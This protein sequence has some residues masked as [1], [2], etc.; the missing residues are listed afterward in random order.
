M[1][2]IQ[3]RPHQERPPQNA[4]RPPERKYLSFSQF[5]GMNTRNARVGLD[6]TDLAW[7]EN[8]M[9]IGPN[10][11][12]G[13][14]GPG[15]AIAVVPGV[16]FTKIYDVFLRG[17]HYKICF[18]TNGAGYQIDDVTG[19]PVVFAPPGT[20]SLPDI[21]VYRAER[22]LIADPTAG[23]CTWDT[24]VFVK[25]GSVSPNLHV[26][27]GGAGYTSPPTFTVTGGSGAV[28]SGTTTILN[29]AVV[30]L[31]LT[32][33][34][35]GDRLGDSLT[36]VFSGGG[37]SGASATSY[38]WPFIGFTPNSVAV[39]QN[40]VFITGAR[41]GAPLS[42]AR[43]MAYSG[44]TGIDANN[45]ISYDNFVN[46]GTGSSS[47]VDA[48]LSEGITCVR[49]LNNFLYIF[50]SSSVRQIGSKSVVGS[51]I[52]TNFIITT[53]SSDQGTI[54]KDSVVSY[55][56]FVF[57]ANMTGVFAIFGATVQ[58][59]SGPMDGIF[60]LVS[61]SGVSPQAAVFD[62]LNKHVYVLLLQI[63]DPVAGVRNVMIA[64]VDDAW[65]LLSAGNVLAIT[66]ESNS[67]SF[68][69]WGSHGGDI[70]PLFSD[71]TV[72]VSIRVST[73]LTED[74]DPM[75]NKR[76]LRS[77]ISHF[78]GSGAPMLTWSLESDNGAVQY[79]YTFAKTLQ[80][81]SKF[82]PITFTNSLGQPINFTA[83]GYLFKPLPSAGSGVYLGGT[84]TGIVAGITLTGIVIEYQPDV[85]MRSS[86]V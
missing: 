24:V 63:N 10:N 78:V 38:V 7:C 62:V 2:E 58:K 56:K 77:A 76:A 20:F 83:G 16:M 34:G 72:A 52:I 33:P 74:R 43:I 5:K 40:Q 15:A 46:Q 26:T 69:L 45:P 68:S 51:P 29:G 49:S 85:P 30:S 44:I 86:N 48:D 61:F 8:V 3:P 25:Q 6:P 31:Q 36:V 66:A 54:W 55:N 41:I 50:G 42:T 70:T 67:S 71:P 82:G 64:L 37:G 32:V 65:F 27:N 19:T 80:F 18:A 57:F 59:V 12:Q 4:P 81:V 21:T 73:S 23:Y 14:P 9:P 53:I 13:V 84:L 28:A 22:I 17:L 39:W 60:L 35:S 47:I 75:T 11:L 1:P 79:P